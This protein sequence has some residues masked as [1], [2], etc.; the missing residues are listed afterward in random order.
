MR[1]TAFLVTCLATVASCIPAQ[2]VADNINQLTTL[3]RNL[4]T[5]A[6]SLTILDG[7]LLAVGQGNFPVRRITFNDSLNEIR[8]NSAGSAHN[9]RFY[10]D[11]QRWHWISERH[12]PRD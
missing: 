6:K 12:E 5:P 11:R 7:P 3:S 1:F 10:R 4:Q 2:Q 9:H 8:T